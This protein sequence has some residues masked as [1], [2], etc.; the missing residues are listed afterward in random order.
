MKGDLVLVEEKD[1]GFY[2]ALWQHKKIKFHQ[3]KV[4]MNYIKHQA[5]VQGI[6]SRKKIGSGLLMRSKSDHEQGKIA[7]IHKKESD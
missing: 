4:T 5:K 6:L 3:G 2:N 7:A 1:K